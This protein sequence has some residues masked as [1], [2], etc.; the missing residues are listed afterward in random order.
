VHDGYRYRVDLL[1]RDTPPRRANRPLE[2]LGRLSPFQG[3][4]ASKIQPPHGTQPRPAAAEEGT[5]PVGG[6]TGVVGGSGSGGVEPNPLSGYGG[7]NRRG[8]CR[9]Q[10]TR[11]V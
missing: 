9:S 5:T 3:V 2:D 1:C 10:L 8:L 4:Q 7:C 6:V 11:L